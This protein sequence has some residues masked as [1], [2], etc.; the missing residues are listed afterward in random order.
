LIIAPVRIAE[1]SPV[2]AEAM[3][4]LPRLGHVYRDKEQARQRK[5]GIDKSDVLRYF[6]IE[7]R[8]R[9]KFRSN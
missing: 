9:Y 2:E 1:V 3:V 6:N 7:N 4:Y 5:G 8:E